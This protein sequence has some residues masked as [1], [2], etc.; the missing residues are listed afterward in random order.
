MRHHEDPRRNLRAVESSA[1]P[2]SA[3]SDPD[4]QDWFDEYVTVTDGA[5]AINTGNIGEFFAI[6]AAKGLSVEDADGIFEK[7]VEIKRA[8]ND[9]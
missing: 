1:D 9:G 2:Q 4:V 6:L 8:G 3:L 7:L 5:V